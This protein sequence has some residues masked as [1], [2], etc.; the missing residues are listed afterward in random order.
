ML[1]RVLRK[2]GLLKDS[3]ICLQCLCSSLKV[4]NRFSSDLPL[5]GPFESLSTQS[6][7]LSSPLQ[8]TQ[9][10][11]N[12]IGC[13]D[14]CRQSPRATVS[15]LFC[16]LSRWLACECLFLTKH[17]TVMLCVNSR[18]MHLLKID[19]QS[20]PVPKSWCRKKVLLWCSSGLMIGRPR[21]ML[22]VTRG[23]ISLPMQSRQESSRQLTRSW[24]YGMQT[25]LRFGVIRPIAL[26]RRTDMLL[27]SRPYS[28]CSRKDS[29][30]MIGREQLV[31][32]LYVHRWVWLNVRLKGTF[33]PI[34]SRLTVLCIVV[35]P[36][37]LLTSACWRERLGLTMV[38]WM[39]WKRVCSICRVP[40]M[41]CL[42]GRF[43]VM[44]L[45]R[46]MGWSKRM[47]ALWLP[48]RTDSR[49]WKCLIT[50]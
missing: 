14:L 48:S 43:L 46:S 26:K 6:L 38:A 47:T 27:Q 45:C 35:V 31:V 40:C 24:R 33:L 41:A 19:E 1:R 28:G 32:T 49:C 17:L 18:V 11:R 4:P 8:L 39:C 15:T 21:P 34:V 20:G 9:I 44:I 25:I 23:G 13:C 16:G 2:T 7:F 10:G 42:G 36:S 3:V 50:I 22:V 29:E 5:P 37:M 30:C 12:M